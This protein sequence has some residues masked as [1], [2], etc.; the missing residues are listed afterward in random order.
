METIQELREKY[1][2]LNKE[3]Y[4]IYNKILELE[5]QEI[6]KKFT[7]GEC[8]LDTWNN[9]FK[10]IIAIDCDE[11]CSICVNEDSICREFTTL[12]SIRDWKKITSEQFKSAYLAI[13]KDIQD[14]DLDDTK[15]S[16]WDIALKSI[17][18]SINKEK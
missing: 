5:D 18:N 4:I 3:R 6:L 11:F 16:N 8:Y 17:V 12:E 13:I 10:K 15:E 7:V 2:K 14:P 1:S 9:N